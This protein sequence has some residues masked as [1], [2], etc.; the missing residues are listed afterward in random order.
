[1]RQRQ[2]FLFSLLLFL[3]GQ[4]SSLALSCAF[5][6]ITYDTLAPGIVERTSCERFSQ[7]HCSIDTISATKLLTALKDSLGSHKYAFIAELFPEEMGTPVTERVDFKILHSFG[8]ELDGSLFSVTSNGPYIWVDKWEV[9]K[10]RIFFGFSDSLHHDKA[11]GFFPKGYCYTKPQG[12][13]IIG[14]QIKNREFPK[15][16]ISL[17]EFLQTLPSTIKKQKAPALSGRSRMDGNNSKFLRNILGRLNDAPIWNGKNPKI[18][19]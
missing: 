19:K 8:K 7:E 6:T 17:H 9:L 13:E 12:F 4:G 3:G 18:L 1:M 11:L 16:S 15:V 5:P 10:G 2:I 14:N